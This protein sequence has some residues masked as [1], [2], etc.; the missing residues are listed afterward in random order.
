MTK[1]QHSIWKSERTPT[2]WF[3]FMG[4]KILKA[5]LIIVKCECTAS[6]FPV[7]SLNLFDHLLWYSM[8]GAWYDAEYLRYTE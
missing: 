8:P 6:I 7:T 2:N 1:K 4:P 3:S 5:M